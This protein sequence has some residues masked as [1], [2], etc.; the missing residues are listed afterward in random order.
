MKENVIITAS[1]KKYGDFLIEHWYKSLKE[2]CNLSNIYIFVIDYGLSV[3]QK[4]YLKHNDI[5]VF[6]GKRNGH[7]VIIRFREIN[8]ILSA[9]NYNQ[10]LLC[11]SGDI[12]FQKDISPLLNKTKTNSGQFKSISGHLSRYLLTMY[13][14]RII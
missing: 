12:I 8:T 13:F 6:E 9:Y 3:A 10:V 14:F 2:N 7:V 11:D 5:S 4:Y 1:D